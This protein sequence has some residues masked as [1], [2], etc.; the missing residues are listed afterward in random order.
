MNKRRKNK[1]RWLIRRSTFDALLIAMRTPRLT[2]EDCRDKSF[3]KSTK[4]Y[5]QFFTLSW[6]KTPRLLYFIFMSNLYSLLNITEKSSGPPQS[7]INVGDLLFDWLPRERSWT[8]FFNPHY[9][10]YL[11]QYSFTSCAQ[12]PTSA[13]GRWY[14]DLVVAMITEFEESLRLWKRTWN[15][16]RFSR[17][18]WN[19][20]EISVK[21]CATLCETQ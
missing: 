10:V 12:R 20:E 11:L 7:P 14:F 18:I 6:L 1:I 2:R 19:G 16:A 5:L 3:K 15:I 21:R 4:K 8:P 13:F 17:V 9:F